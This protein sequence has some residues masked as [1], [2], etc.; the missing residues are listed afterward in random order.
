MRDQEEQAP[1][2]ARRAEKLKEEEA[3]LLAK[4]QAR[5]KAYLARGEIIEKASKAKEAK[6]AQNLADEEA[7]GLT[8]EKARK[9]AYLARE[10]TI[11]QTQEARKLKAK[12]QPQ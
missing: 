7:K 4:E 10:K 12:K 8:R 5:K 2:E 3:G 6:H 1:E 9:E 11:A